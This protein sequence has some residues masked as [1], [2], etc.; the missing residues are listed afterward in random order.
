[1]TRRETKFIRDLEKKMAADM[2]R[3]TREAKKKAFAEVMGKEKVK[4][5]GDIFA[6]LDG[7]SRKAKEMAAYGRIQH[8]AMLGRSPKQIV[9]IME[10]KTGKGN[11][12]IDL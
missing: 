5:Y 6:I 1:M 4:T 8:F 3:R 10:P 7:L 12:K 11:E 9:E 2:A